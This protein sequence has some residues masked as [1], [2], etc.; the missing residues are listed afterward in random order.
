VPHVTW[1]RVNPP[2]KMSKMGAT[3]QLRK[4]S[5]GTRVL[6]LVPLKGL[7]KVTSRYLRVS[8]FWSFY[9][10]DLLKHL[11]REAPKRTLEIYLFKIQAAPELQRY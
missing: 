10:L 5:K 2:M 8:E 11:K 6:R 7:G 3:C 1:N 9:C 4:D